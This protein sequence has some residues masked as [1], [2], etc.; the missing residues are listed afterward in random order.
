ME[1]KYD[2]AISYQSEM[3]KKAQKITDYLKTEG[4]NVFFAPEQ[5]LDMISEKLHK[6]L[7]NIYRN[8]SFLRLLLV[9]DS[10]LSSEWTLLEKRVSE[11]QSESD[12]KRRIVV[13]YTET[14]SLPPDLKEL[15]YI[16]G[17]CKYEDQIAVF[18]AEY[19]RKLS[20]E[21]TGNDSKKETNQREKEKVVINNNGVMIG[22]HAHFDNFNFG[23]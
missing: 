10:Y 14:K 12:K 18:T 9:S 19:F 22:D 16:D 4:I 15:V 17:K 8:Q 21:F 13:D 6:A 20:L 1:Y 11:S 5:Q 3:E 23:R 7:Y 2:V